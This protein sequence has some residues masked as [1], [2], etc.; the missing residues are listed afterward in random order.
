LN[1]G[2]SNVR[3]R[4]LPVGSVSV[5]ADKKIGTT[6]IGNVQNS[7]GSVLADASVSVTNLGFSMLSGGEE[8][9][10]C[11]NPTQSQIF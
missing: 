9:P 2:I 5:R 11:V 8:N 7:Q 3:R 1:Q 4:V 6:F 10:S